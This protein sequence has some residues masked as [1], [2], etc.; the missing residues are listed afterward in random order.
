MRLLENLKK[1][2]QKGRT[3]LNGTNFTPRIEKAR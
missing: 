3:T 2:N 1:I